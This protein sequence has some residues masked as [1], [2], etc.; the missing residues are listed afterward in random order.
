M[1]NPIHRV[2]SLIRFILQGSFKEP[3]RKG[4]SLIE[5]LVVVA[6]IGV[7]AT[8]AIPAYNKYR[9]SAVQSTVNREAS[10]ILKAF[11]ACLTQDTVDTCSH[12]NINGTISKFCIATAQAKAPDTN[13]CLVGRKAGTDK[14][15]ISA[16]RKSAGGTKHHCYQIKATSGSVKGFSGYFCKKADG[17]CKI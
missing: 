5:L 13:T 9:V 15:C 4:F 10:Q 17:E 14:V 11:Q 16:H 12:P 3:K 6:I 8:V 1:K 7:L 2:K